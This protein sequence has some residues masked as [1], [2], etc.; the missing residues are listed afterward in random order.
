[1]KGLFLPL[2]AALLAAAVP[3]TAHPL[4]AQRVSAPNAQA[5]QVRIPFASFGTIRNFR[6]VGDDVVYLQGTHR[7]W[8]RAELNGPC[9][10]LPAALRIGFDTRFNGSTLDNT[11]TLIVGSGERC[12]ISSLT[13]AE[14]P[15]PRR[16]R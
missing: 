15:P 11:S 6:P 2:T 10:S 12:R 16:R 8:Y 13:R 5:E 7:R 14:G 4:E 1:M 9:I 3:A